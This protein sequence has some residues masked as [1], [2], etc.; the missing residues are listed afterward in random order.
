MGSR[1]S[2]RS[3]PRIRSGSP[4]RSTRARGSRRTCELFVGASGLRALQLAL[5]TATAGLGGE[6]QIAVDDAQRL[7]DC[8][9][10]LGIGEV[11]RDG[12]VG[13]LAEDDVLARQRVHRPAES[14]ALHPVAIGDEALKVR[15]IA[16]E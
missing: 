1:C 13:L 4:T 16:E 14:G 7:V 15:C 12:A 10:N 11:A 9:G 8:A 5:E 2:P 3:L 6:L